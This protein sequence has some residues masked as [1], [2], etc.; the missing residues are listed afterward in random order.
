ASYKLG[1]V[2]SFSFWGGGADPVVESMSWLDGGA[3]NPHCTY[4]PTWT[5]YTISNIVI[6]NSKQAPFSNY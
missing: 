6:E 1:H 4:K 2:L 3:K 5:G